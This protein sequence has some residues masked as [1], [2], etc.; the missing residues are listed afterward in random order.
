MSADNRPVCGYTREYRLDEIGYDIHVD[1]PDLPTHAILERDRETGEWR[2]HMNEGRWTYACDFCV[3]E[4]FRVADPNWKAVPLKSA[5]WLDDRM[6]KRGV[7]ATSQQRCP[8]CGRE[9]AA[10]A[11][12]RKLY[13]DEGCGPNRSIALPEDPECPADVEAAKLVNMGEVNR[14]PLSRTSDMV[15]VYRP[16]PRAHLMDGAYLI[17]TDYAGSTF[18]LHIDDFDAMAAFLKSTKRFIEGRKPGDIGGEPNE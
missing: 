15:R 13:S 2:R 18:L 3:G 7:L 5:V 14:L 9:G 6:T 16:D 17:G 4:R 10:G 8:A 12:H 11:P 1:C